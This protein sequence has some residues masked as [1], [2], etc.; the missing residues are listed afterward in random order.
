MAQKHSASYAM[1]EPINTAVPQPLSHADDLEITEKKGDTASAAT[2]SASLCFFCGYNRHP[3]S[4]CP[5]REAMCLKCKKKGHYAKVCQSVKQS[6][7]P[8]NSK[9]SAAML[10]TLAGATPSCLDKSVRHS[11][12]NGIPVNAL[13]DTGSSENF[14]HNNIVKLNK[15]TIHPDKGEVSMADVSLSSKILGQCTVDLELQGETY[16]GVKLKVLPSL[17][18]DV[19]LGHEFLQNHSALE[20]AFGG[21]RPPLK[22]CG[23]AAVK[24]PAPFLFRNLVA[25]CKP[26]TIKS[27]HYSMADKKFI[28]TETE[29]M[30]L[31][32]IIRPS[33]SPWR[34]Q[35]L[36][37]SGENHKKRMVIDHSQTINQFTELD[38]YPLPRIDEMVNNIA[39]YK[40]FSTLDLK[41]AYYQVAIREEEKPYT[42]F[43]A[44]GKLY[45]FNRIPFGVKNGVAA[46]Q[47]V[48]DEILKKEGVKGTFAYVDDV[49]VCGET[50]EEHDKNLTRFL[51]VAKDYNLTLSYDKCDFRVQAINLLGYLIKEGAIRPDPERLQPLLNLPLP[52]DTASLQKSMGML[53]HYSQ[54]IPNFSEKIHPLSHAIGFPLSTDAAL[55]FENLKKDVV[56]LVVQA[57]DPTS[58]FTVE[59]DASDHAIAAILTQNGR[60]VAFFSRTLSNSEQKHSSVEKEAYAIVEALRK[61]KHYLVGHHFKLITDQRNVKFMF[62]TKSASKSKNDKITRWR[63]ELSC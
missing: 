45:E 63:I 26:I 24:V 57:I 9:H 8:L 17:C 53:P 25:E 38:A 4:Q 18:S 2:T 14:V 31:E 51:D 30:L 58:P 60:P 6:N 20:M 48:I 61:W 34:A 16:H 1:A 44:D 21:E 23:L 62:D 19:I 5:A 40:V 7:S 12:I 27:R 13:I 46:Y 32:G 28:E 43:E 3:R 15:L 36:V 37:T 22:I 54:W 59:T 39:K 35:V 41:S 33:N 50:E 10:A 56:D 55:A 49:T 52:K 29:H 42:A 11:K 47:R